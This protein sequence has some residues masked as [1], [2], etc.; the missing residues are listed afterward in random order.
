MSIDDEGYIGAAP[1]A[2]EYLSH[3]AQEMRL[4]RRL[5][6]V[7]A[8]LTLGLLVNLGLGINLLTPQAIAILAVFIGAGLAIAG[9]RTRSAMR[10]I[11][12]SIFQGLDVA[13]AI[14]RSNGGLFANLLGSPIE[15]ED[16]AV[17]QQAAD[18][19][20]AMTTDKWGRAKYRTRGHNL[21]KVAAG[22][23]ADTFSRK[24]PRTDAMTE[25]PEFE[26]LEGELSEAERL[27][28]EANVAYDQ[29]AAERWAEAE[30]KDADLIEAGVERLG[31]LVAT[32]HFANRPAQSA[33]PEPAEHGAPTDNLPLRGKRRKE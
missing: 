32:G 2:P 1:L 20:L 9:A 29:R 26:G 19:E 22:G 15:M 16:L 8:L 14:E 28:E 12:Q 5:N 11:E 7:P 17:L 33:M 18:G 13:H 6:W 30:A 27:V 24:M 23:G 31:D 4:R 3:L 21:D 25:R 10:G